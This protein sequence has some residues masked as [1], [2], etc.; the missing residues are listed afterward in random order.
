[1]KLICNESY[2]NSQ[3]DL[4]KVKELVNFMLSFDMSE[5][6]SIQEQKKELEKYI[7]T[8]KD[9]VLR[10]ADLLLEKEKLESADVAMILNEGI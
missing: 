6:F 10:L 7:E 1:M 9:K 5:D 3:N 4:L 8:M 2:T